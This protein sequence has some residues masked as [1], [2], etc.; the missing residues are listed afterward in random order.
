[1]P[2]EPLSQDTSPEIERLQI[3]GWRRMTMEQKAAVVSGLTQAVV[4][5]ALAGIRQRHPDAPPR[6][7]L[8]RFALITLGPD[9]ASRACPEVATLDPQ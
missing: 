8:L 2:E 4:D 9:L 1:V 3:E 7:Q 5:L 6:E